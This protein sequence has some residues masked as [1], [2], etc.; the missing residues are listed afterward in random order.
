MAKLTPQEQADKLARRLKSSTTDIQRGI[1][2]T[3]VAPGIAAGKAQEKM[4]QNINAAIDD[5]RWKRGVEGVTLEDWKRKTISKGIGR[6]AAG[7]D[8]AMPRLVEV[9]TN[10]QQAQSSIDS[11][12]ASMPSMTLQD[13]INRMVTQVTEMSKQKGRI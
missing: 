4:R 10:L 9:A 6:I 12:L 11:K 3:A 2:R 8:E 7:V 1:E 5:G 13:S